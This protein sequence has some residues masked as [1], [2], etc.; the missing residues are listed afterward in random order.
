MG[1]QLEKIPSQLDDNEI[2]AKVLQNRGNSFEVLVPESHL[3]KVLK[4]NG[5]EERQILVAL[6]P[7][8]R[9]KIFVQRNG[10][11]VVS[12]ENIGPNGKLKGEISA[13]V[14]DPKSWHRAL[15]DWPA[16]FTVIKQTHEILELPPSLSE[17]EYS[18][19][20]SEV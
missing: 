16:E 11:V 8:L 19:D 6:S 3:H 1:K 4:C 2:I 7:S 13:V 10:F 12:L 17:E 18:S 14:A 5:A 15:E 9:K 20:S